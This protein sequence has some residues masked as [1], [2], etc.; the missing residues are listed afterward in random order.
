MIESNSTSEPRTSL[1]GRAMERDQVAWE[2]LGDLYGPV[3]AHWCRDFG[4]GSMAIAD[5]VQEVFLSISKS[6]DRFR[7]P[8]GAGAFRNWLWKIIHSKVIDVVR[9]QPLTVEGGTDNLRTIHD[10]LD[11]NSLP[12]NDPSDTE[13]LFELTSRALEQTRSEFQVA[14][15]RAFWRTTVN[16]LSSEAVPKEL[17]VS[18]VGVRQA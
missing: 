10:L 7:S 9:K 15:W 11:P 5:I 6:L 17:G 13:A 16:G 14:T 4:L 8:P 1:L 12:E 3:V 2:Q 18:P